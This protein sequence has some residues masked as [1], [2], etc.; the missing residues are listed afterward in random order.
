M[1]TIWSR[2]FEFGKCP[3]TPD[4]LER[5]NCRVI[6]RFKSPPITALWGVGL[7]SGSNGRSHGELSTAGRRCGIFLVPS[8]CASVDN[9]PSIFLQFALPKKIERKCRSVFICNQ[10]TESAINHK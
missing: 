3:L 10:S 1:F 2:I 6:A 9:S 4:A 7:V 8:L 5:S